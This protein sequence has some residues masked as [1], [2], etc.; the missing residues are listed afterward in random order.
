MSDHPGR[1]NSERILFLDGTA[2]PPFQGGESIF[3]ILVS[4]ELGNTPFLRR[5]A[6]KK[7]NE[8]NSFTPSMTD[9]NAATYENRRRS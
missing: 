8:R 1:A 4:F 5:S 9:D 7:R 2:T 6:A 3:Y